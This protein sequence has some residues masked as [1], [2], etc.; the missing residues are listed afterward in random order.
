MEARR[1]KEEERKRQVEEQ[2]KLNSVCYIL[3]LRIWILLLCQKYDSFF[4]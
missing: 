3:F 1:V 2:E 4:G